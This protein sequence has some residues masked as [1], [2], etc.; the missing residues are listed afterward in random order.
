[1]RGEVA[2]DGLARVE[3]GGEVGFLQSSKTNLCSG[4]RLDKIAVN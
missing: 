3:W 2:G 4:E 1:M